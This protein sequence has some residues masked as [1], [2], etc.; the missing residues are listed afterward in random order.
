[1]ASQADLKVVEVAL[2]RRAD[3]QFRPLRATLYHL[4]QSQVDLG[5]LDKILQRGKEDPAARSD[6]ENENGICARCNRPIA[7]ENLALDSGAG[8]PVHREC[9]PKD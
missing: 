1:V 8:R 9:P 7:R 6:F 3:W 4:T 2:Y 5:F